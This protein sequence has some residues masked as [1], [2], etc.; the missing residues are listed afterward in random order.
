[1][2]TKQNGIYNRTILDNG[3]RIVSEK[4]PGVRSTAIGIWVDV[5]SRNE[6]VEKNGITHF[7]EHML[8]KGTR[9]RS[10]QAIALSLEA[11]GGSLNAY[12]SREQTC[13][14]ALV[15]DQ[16]LELAIDVL[17]DILMNS[18]ITP[19]NIEREKSVVAEEIRE[20]DETPSDRIHELFSD[21]FWRGQPLGWP[22]MGAEK[23][24]FTFSRPMIRKYI[25]DNYLAGRI[26]IAATGNI[27]HQKLV[28]LIKE[29][30]NFPPGRDSDCKAAEYPEGFS[31]RFIKNGSSQTH[32]CIGFP[33]IDYSSPG[34]LSLLALNNYLGGGMSSVLF[35]K[36]REDRGMAYTVF[37]FPDFYRDCGVF[38]AYLATDRKHL[39]EAVETMLKEF[40]KIK[41]SRLP[42]EKIEMIKDQLKG[43]LVLGMESTSSRMN[44][45]GRQEIITGR[46]I[47][48]KESLRAINRL[49]GNNIV[50][51]A[52]KILDPNNITVTVLGP[53]SETDISKVDWSLL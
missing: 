40:R 20:V 46:Y 1:M 52:R 31:S 45:L 13:F 26:V 24:I 36:I 42:D 28:S 47:S 7:I 44:R 9:S 33:G 29:K 35:Q 37:T 6:T 10:A 23:N 49:T 18:T 19:V 51:V 32:I 14:H 4:I 17:S 50:E 22:I 21:H 43:N 27:S 53:A 15:L 16:H 5:G 2:T 41:K 34:R 48:L 12:T 30:F 11:L 38:G 25:K 39:H 8:F 3:L